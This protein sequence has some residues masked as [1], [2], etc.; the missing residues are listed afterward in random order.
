MLRRPPKHLR[1]NSNETMRREVR[2]LSAL[3]GTPVP[4]PG[5][6]AACPQEDVIG[7][8]FYLMEPIEGF[9]P[10]DEMPA[11]HAGDPAV[12]HTMGLEMVD[13]IA[14]LS[15]V[16]YAAAGLQT[17]GKLDGFLDRQ[18]GRWRS[19]LESYA[20][21]EGWPGL[22]R[23]PRRRRD[24]RLADR[25]T[26]EELRSR[27]DPRRFPLGQRALRP[28]LARAWRRWSTGS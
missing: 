17:L 7:A 6:I 26:A 27:P 16:D 24:R 8:S 15:Q 13:A 18:V 12:R 19:Q 3:A 20:A 4:H 23:H 1:A 28:R 22:G 11:L 21:F 5:M 14:H 10:R 2:V 9:T 25:A